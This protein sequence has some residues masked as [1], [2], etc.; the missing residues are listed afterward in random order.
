MAFQHTLYLKRHAEDIKG[1]PDIHE[2]RLYFWS[3]GARNFAHEVQ[4]HGT[5]VDDHHYHF[6]PLQA[7]IFLAK[8]TQEFVAQRMELMDS[9]EDFLDNVFRNED[10]KADEKQLESYAIL[11]RTKNRMDEVSYWYT[12]TFGDEFR[13][14]RIM[15][16]FTTLVSRMKEDDVLVWEM[17]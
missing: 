9:Y 7:A 14:K 15:D 6:T 5:K 16:G 12:N 3:N 10:M 13:L 1:L 2:N 4:V 11:R 17:G 8:L